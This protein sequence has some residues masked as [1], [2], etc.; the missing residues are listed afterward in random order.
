M[1]AAVATVLAVTSASPV[2]AQ[3][4]LD[5]AMAQRLDAAIQQAM[6]TAS[7]PGA[8]VGIW[9]PDGS[10]V[11]GFGV[12]DKATGAPV[13]PD[14]Y[15]RIGSVTKTFT[16][17][18][19]LQ[20]ADQGRLGLD[21]PIALY[22][23]G[24][25][26]GNELTLR[27]LARMQSGLYNYSATKEFDQALRT[28]PHRHY[29]PQELLDWAFAQPAVFDPGEGFD[30]S[31]TNTILLG[32]V[33]EKVS[34]QSLPDYI[35]DH[36]LTPLGMNHTSLPI[37][38]ALPDPHAQGYTDQIGPVTT[39]TDWD[40]SWAW[41]AGGM[42][43]TLDDLR[44]WAPAVATGQLL[45]PGMQAQRMQMVG[46]PGYPPPSGFGLGIDNNGGWIGHGGALPGYET[47]IGYL[48]EQQTTLV[49]LTNT[50]IPYNDQSRGH[51][52]SVANE[53]TKII[54]P[55]HVTLTAT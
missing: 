16:V 9:G 6:H 28:D 13:T 25:P 40:P 34:G 24:V 30:Y 23:D 1:A 38:N 46:V 36:I 26:R 41:A 43:S 2:G 53:I 39:A 15:S 44:I 27:Q 21:D 10:Y 12:A 4:T 45:S 3:P 29:S 20:L 42:I 55:H 31:N 19:V 7:I 51:V 22:V 37:T 14:F 52:T 54:S 49:V 47:V 11:R 17:T 35:R 50:D 32:L 8:I 48:P 5:A 18:G 33:V